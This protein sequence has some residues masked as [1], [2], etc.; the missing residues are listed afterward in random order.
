MTRDAH[1][2]TR[3]GFLDTAARFVGGL[4]LTVAPGAV[5]ATPAS[6]QSAMK[7]I[8][9][10]ATVAKGKVKLE[11]P[12][13]VENGNSVTMVVSVESPMTIEDHVKSIHVLNEKNPQPN[14]IN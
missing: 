1:S 3:R 12:P 11:L 7:K 2:P 4:L 9:G 5:R 6:M 13:L 8:V 10:E 14:V